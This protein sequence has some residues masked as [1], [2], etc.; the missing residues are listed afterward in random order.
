MT[1]SFLPRLKA[2]GYA[3]TD[4]G[5]VPDSFI[6]ENDLLVIRGMIVDGIFLNDAKGRQIVKAWD[7]GKKLKKPKN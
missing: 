7:G 1:S 3:T 6:L 2:I 5:E 4:S